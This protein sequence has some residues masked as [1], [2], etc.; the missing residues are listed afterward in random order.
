[1]TNDDLIAGADTVCEIIRTALGPF[2]ANKLLIQED[3]T[4]TTTASS[5]ELLERFDVVDPAV[6]LL[7]SAGTGFRERYGDGA[8]TVVALTGSLL[9]AADRLVAD[10]LHPATIEQGYREGLDIAVDALNQSGRP[11]SEQEPA[12]VARTALTGTRNPRVRQTVATQI[13]E[14]VDAVGTSAN[15]DIQV[16][17]RTGGSA[18]ETELVTGTVLERGPVHESMPRSAQHE[19]IAVLSATVDVPHVGSQLGDVSRR[20]TFEVDSFEDRAALA[21]H[22]SETFASRLESVT[23]MGCTAI[24]TEGAINERVET[25]LAAEGVLGVHRVDTDELRQIARTTGAVVV[26]TL[27]SITEEALGTASIDVQRMAGRDMTV[28]ESETGTTAYTLFCRAPDPRAASAFEHSVAAAIASTTAAVRD[29]YIVPGGGAAEATAA[30]A[31]NQ[32]SLSLDGRHQLAADAFGTALTDIPR[33]LAETAGI[34][35]NEAVIDL[36]ADRAD[37]HDTTGVDALAGTT[38]DVLTDTQIIEPVS[39]KREMFSA[40]TDLAVQLLRID[41]KV[42][43]TDLSDESRVEDAAEASE[44]VPATQGRTRDQPPSGRGV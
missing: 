4:V 12:A 23:D 8:G 11:L 33:A 29:G 22:E 36:R 42:V 32:R 9:R 25:K 2:G 37:G 18:T 16:V 1:M 24:V 31:V 20:V 21:E 28:V 7:E 6:T 13:A 19:G 15:E 40:A 43:A 41:D 10:G 44:D 35:G 39:I 34:D 38:T 14:A 17:S 30:H 27:Q 5:T 26:P 3:G